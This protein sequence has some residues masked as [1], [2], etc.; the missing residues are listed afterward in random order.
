MVEEIFQRFDT[1]D[2]LRREEDDDVTKCYGLLRVRGEAYLRYEKALIDRLCG[3]AR[4]VYV[5][6]TTPTGT[7]EYPV[8]VVNS[9]VLQSEI[10]NALAE[11]P[12]NPDHPCEFAAIW[13]YSHWKDELHVSLRA[14]QAS[15]IDLSEVTRQIKGILKGGGHAKASGCSING[16]DV[17]A[18]FRP[19]SLASDE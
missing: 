6:C 2:A 17:K 18:V 8:K 9:P 19:S 11:A 10:G 12:A 5:T 14:S 1:I 13:R 16:S 3:E 4:T 15:T 7:K